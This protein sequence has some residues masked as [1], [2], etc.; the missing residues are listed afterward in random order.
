MFCGTHGTTQVT[1]VSRENWGT[2]VTIAIFFGVLLYAIPVS[3]LSSVQAIAQL[4]PSMESGS[5]LLF[6]V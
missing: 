5:A 4:A 1:G 2:I 3:A 6:S